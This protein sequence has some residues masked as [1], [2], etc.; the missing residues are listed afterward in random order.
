MEHLRSG[1][2]KQ[3]SDLERRT[4]SKKDRVS[5]GDLNQALV[6]RSPFQTARESIEDLPID[7][8]QRCSLI[9]DYRDPTVSKD[10]IVV[11]TSNS[12][13]CIDGWEQIQTASSKKETHIRCH[14]FNLQNCSEQELAI[15]KVAVRTMPQGGRASYSEVIRNTRLLCNMFTSS[16]ENPLMY[17]HGGARRGNNY[18]S[19]NREENVREILA[20]RLGKNL[21]TICKYLNYAEY[22]DPETLEVLVDLKADKRF[23]ETAQRSKR[24]LI[25]N[26]RQE[27]HSDEQVETRICSA[28]LDMFKEYSDTGR[29]RLML[30]HGESDQAEE[31]DAGTEQN[32]HQDGVS[33]KQ[34]PSSCSSPA[35]DSLQDQPLTVEKVR[36]DLRDTAQRVLEIADSLEPSEQEFTEAIRREIFTLTRIS[37][38]AKH[39]KGNTTLQTHTEGTA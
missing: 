32:V 6:V 10:P 28:L 23:F 33:T 35:T 38:A 14:V 24:V 3:S 27:G 17:S 22:L 31:E 2:S 39:L 11:R 25:K 15:R 21:G 8:I 19:N 7:Q 5:P 36:Q 18:T 9:P 29:I 4:S 20:E 12:C 30:E 13:H 26:L 16:L 34:L 1:K 37:L